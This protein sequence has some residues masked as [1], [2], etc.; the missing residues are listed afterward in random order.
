M[1]QGFRLAKR[2]TPKKTK[3]AQRQVLRSTATMPYLP[4][5]RGPFAKQKA[6]NKT[7]KC[8]SLC[9]RL[10]IFLGPYQPS[11]VSGGEA[12]TAGEG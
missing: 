11:I 12:S 6:P 1:P 8:F 10:P 5:P 2:M 9:W 3:T 7:V 4:G